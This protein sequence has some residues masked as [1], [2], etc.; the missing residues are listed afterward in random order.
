MKGAGRSAGSSA[1]SLR[2]VGRALLCTFS[3]AALQVYEVSPTSATASAGLSSAHRER[4]RDAFE[5]VVEELGIPGAQAAVRRGGRPLWSGV[6]GTL[7]DAV[8]VRPEDRF[9]IASTTKPI[10]AT[11]LM[12][13]VE[14]H[15]VRL[16][17]TVADFAID[18]PN[19]ER[20]TLRMLLAHRSGLPEYF[21]DPLVAV[22]LLDPR[23]HWTRAQVLAAISR[24]PAAFAPGERFEYANS[25]YIVA[26][27][28]IERITGQPIE[29]ILSRRVAAPLGLATL[30]FREHLPGSRIAHGHQPT[31]G[32]LG[33]AQ[34]QYDLAGGRTPSDVIGPVWTDG[35]IAASARDLARFSA[36]LFAGEIVSRRTVARMTPDGHY[37]LGLQVGPS[38]TGGPL[39]EH[40]GGYGGF[41]ANLGF[42]P[43]TKTSVAVVANTA[44]EDAAVELA[45]AIRV[46]VGR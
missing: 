45:R 19:A 46:A 17:D 28:V 2:V 16:D 8:Q 38:P 39:Y 9:V 43:R 7:D 29:T 26:G 15:R 14:R 24:Q 13:L 22:A 5:R 25:N 42:D 18:V 21:D 27:E 10:V 6:S 35:G 30:S 41:S 3:L 31:L 32:F 12:G 4:V 44:P 36:A 23:H 33:P 34:D 37:G 20:I 1:S 11:L 40:P